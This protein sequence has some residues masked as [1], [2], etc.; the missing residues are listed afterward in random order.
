M[1]S[2]SDP[3]LAADE[4]SISVSQMKIVSFSGLQR[5]LRAEGGS[6]KR[7]WRDAATVGNRFCL[8]DTK[9]ADESKN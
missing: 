3:P 6:G 4:E 5:Y 1:I 2:R 9:D 8:G 7:F